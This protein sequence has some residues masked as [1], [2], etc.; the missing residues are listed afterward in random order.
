MGAFDYLLR[1]F[2]MNL[3]RTHSDNTDFR[4]LVEL[5]D[6]DLAVRDGE[7]HSFYAQFNKVDA[8]RNVVVA[9]V[10]GEPVGC[11]A[12]K[13][14]WPEAVEIKRMFVRPGHR[15]QGVAAAVLSGLEKWAAELRYKEC[16]LETGFKQPEAIRLYEKSGYTRIPNYGQYDG[17][18]TS[19]CMKKMLG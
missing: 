12:F 13:E 10:E 11:G 2:G 6:E 15:G 19:V 14:Y 4:A 1:I 7:D 9:Y 8:I 5:L 18:E 17:V 16:V 3:I